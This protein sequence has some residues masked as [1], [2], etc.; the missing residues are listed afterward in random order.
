MKRGNCRWWRCV[1]GTGS[2]M[3]ICWIFYN[4]L[5]NFMNFS[6]IL[7]RFSKIQTFLFFL[8]VFKNSNFLASNN[9]WDLNYI[10]LH[11]ELAAL[12]W[13]L[14]LSSYKFRS[15]KVIATVNWR[16]RWIKTH[17]IH[18]VDQNRKLIEI[19]IDY[20]V[21][22]ELKLRLLSKKFKQ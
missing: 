11:N 18:F 5:N 10:K 4:F 12:S 2:S 7:Q 17:L 16:S 3:V 15:I 1:M 22:I 8:T 20:G 19:L 14:K 9:A 13:A 21:K 6:K